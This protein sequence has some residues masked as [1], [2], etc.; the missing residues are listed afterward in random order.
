MAQDEYGNMAADYCPN[1]CRYYHSGM[2][3]RAADL[4]DPASLLDPKTGKGV[5]EGCTGC[6]VHS[7]AGDTKSLDTGEV[8]RLLAA[9]A[10]LTQRNA[11]GLTAVELARE[12]NKQR[13]AVNKAMSAE[14]LL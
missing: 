13:D 14:G 6:Y 7:T 1:A 3:V 4:E 8:E 9:G 12:R 5:G 2:E 11:A 10:S